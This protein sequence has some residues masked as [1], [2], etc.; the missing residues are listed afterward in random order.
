MKNIFYEYTTEVFFTLT[1]IGAISVLV[2]VG[3][4]GFLPPPLTHECVSSHVAISQKFNDNNKITYNKPTQVCDIMMH[5]QGDKV[6]YEYSYEYRLEHH[7]ENVFSETL[8][9]DGI[10]KHE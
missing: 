4:L 8:S 7:I 3:Y 9:K 10:A 6:V 2:L 5:K 1:V